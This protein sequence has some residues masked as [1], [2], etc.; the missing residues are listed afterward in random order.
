MLSN[1]QKLLAGYINADKRMDDVSDSLQNEREIR[2]LN[3]SVDMYLVKHGD[4]Y[5]RWYGGN[6]KANYQTRTASEQL[7]NCFYM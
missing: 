4:K 6:D 7:W 5:N 3:Q 1:L 2:M